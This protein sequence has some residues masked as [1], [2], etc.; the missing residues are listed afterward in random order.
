V[1]SSLEDVGE[2]NLLPKEIKHSQLNSEGGF[3]LH[4]FPDIPTAYPT[5]DEW[6]QNEDGFRRIDF[7]AGKNVCDAGEIAV[8]NGGTRNIPDK[9]FIEQDAYALGYEEGKAAGIESTMA[10]GEKVIE[11]LNQTISQVEKFRREVYLNA[12]RESVALALAVAAK[13][14]GS[15]VE[16]K[17]EVVLSTV[18]SA[19]GKVVDY[20][21][22]KIKV[23]P[24]D[25][26]FVKN[27]AS[28]LSGSVENLENVAFEADETVT[29]G[30]CV[31]E[32]NFGDIDAKIENQ[33]EAVASVFK[34]EL[35][36]SDKRSS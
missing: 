29:C 24:D 36:K 32:T 16:T 1:R 3:R 23:S 27:S 13:I 25:F 2:N 20:E 10:S 9:D 12:E 17:K 7:S 34:G 8:G 14:V 22:I 15:E 31:I 5:N 18:K 26:E 19:L 33:L 35:L 30:G 6:E 4:Y 28:E 11:R 21:R